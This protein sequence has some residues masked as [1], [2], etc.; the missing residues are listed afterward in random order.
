MRS[1]IAGGC[2]LPLHEARVRPSMEGDGRMDRW[3]TPLPPLFFLRQATFPNYARVTYGRG[4][5]IYL[6]LPLLLLAVSPD[7]TRLHFFKLVPP[8]P[9]AM[10]P[11][12]LPP[13]RRTL[14]RV[15]RDYA[16]TL[17]VFNVLF[18]SIA[19][20]RHRNF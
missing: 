17:F 6:H 11:R 10:R 16:D 8:S 12:R 5:L 15:I 18:R 2:G 19:A 7:A 1:G 4:G 14:S 13:R 9:Q 3:L 20:E